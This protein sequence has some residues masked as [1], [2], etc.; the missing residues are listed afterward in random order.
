MTIEII[1]LLI[2]LY[3]LEEIIEKMSH[4]ARPCN[5]PMMAGMPL[6]AE[7]WIR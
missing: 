4:G 1:V 3:G 2:F 6:R 7:L 5:V